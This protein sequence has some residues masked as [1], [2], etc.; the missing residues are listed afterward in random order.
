M[1]FSTLLS[2][3]NQV[4]LFELYVADSN[5]I[6]RATEGA[7]GGAGLRALACRVGQL[8]IGDIE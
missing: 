7:G 2:Q 3:T 6:K 5:Y 1:T 4:Y 8:K